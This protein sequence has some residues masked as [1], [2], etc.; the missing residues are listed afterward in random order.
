MKNQQG[1][2]LKIYA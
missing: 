1:K 2:I